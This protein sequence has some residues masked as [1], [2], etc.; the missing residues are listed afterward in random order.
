VTSATTTSDGHFEVTF[1]RD[2]SGCAYAVTTIA[3]SPEAGLSTSAISQSTNPAGSPN[4]VIVTIERANG[5]NVT[6]Y[7]FSLI[8]ACL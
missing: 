6:V 5:S 1:D 2:V 7:G 4:T 8:V 3:F